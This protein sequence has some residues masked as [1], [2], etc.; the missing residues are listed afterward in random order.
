MM[1][2]RIVMGISHLSTWELE[3]MFEKPYPTSMNQHF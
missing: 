2:L 1:I 3:R